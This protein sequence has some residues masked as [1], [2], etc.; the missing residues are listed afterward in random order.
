[1]D[2]RRSGPI[3]AV[4][5]VGLKGTAVVVAHDSDWLA[6]DMDGINDMADDLGL[7]TEDGPGLFLWEGEGRIVYF[8]LEESCETRYAGKCRRVLPAELSGLL[9]MKPPMCPACGGSGVM[10]GDPT[11]PTGSIRRQDVPCPEC[12]QQ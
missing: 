6:A 3:R 8:G 12:Q 5:A 11:A 7:D 4:I 9:A 2:S 1:M 10:E